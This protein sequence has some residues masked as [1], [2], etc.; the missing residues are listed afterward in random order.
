MALV[1][2]G[3]VALVLSLIFR[4]RLRRLASVSRNSVATVFNKTFVVFDPYTQKT[5]FHRFL[6]LLPFVP[7]I[8][9]FGMAVL[10]L[11]II[12]SGLLLTLLVSILALSLIIVEESPEAY[13][14]SKLLI[15]AIE[16]GS[17]LG[18]GDM[19]LLALTKR[20]LPRLSYYYLGLSAFLFVL[21]TVLPY[22]WLQFLWLFAVGLG[23]LLQISTT[24]GPTSWMLAILLYAAALTGFVTLAALAKSRLFGHH[25]ETNPM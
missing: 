10:L 22:V 2:M 5:I 3:V 23:S 9:G 15:K 11:V 6:S 13:A 20:I 7:V 4:L 25:I 8:C 18:T 14:E 12:E 19:R 21:A 24:A 1:A 17:N 16:D